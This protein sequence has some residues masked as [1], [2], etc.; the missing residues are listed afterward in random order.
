MLIDQKV[1]FD[2]MAKKI[3]VKKTHANAPYVNQ[4]AQMKKMG[5]DGFG[6][7]KLVG[8]VPMHMLAQWIKEAGLDWSDNEAIRQVIRRKLLS[9]EFD[10]LRPWEGTF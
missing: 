4:V 3:I 2:E 8:R 10:K 9:G 6:E 5:I 1:A 7:N